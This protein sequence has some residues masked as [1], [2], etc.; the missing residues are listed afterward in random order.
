MI[1]I[2]TYAVILTIM[3]QWHNTTIIYNEWDIFLRWCDSHVLLHVQ[4]TSVSNLWHL[5]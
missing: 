3:V 1:L 2:L 5:H 4:G